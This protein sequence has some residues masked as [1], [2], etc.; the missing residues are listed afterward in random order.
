MGQTATFSVVASGVG[1]SYQWIGPDGR[2]LSDRLGE[3]E[4]SN[5]ATL[6]IRNSGSSNAASYRC[7][8]SNSGG[9]VTSFPALLT[10]GK[11]CRRLF[12]CFKYCVKVWSCLTPSTELQIPAPSMRVTSTTCVLVAPS[13]WEPLVPWSWRE[14]NAALIRRHCRTPCPSDAS[15]ALVRMLIRIN[16]RCVYVRTLW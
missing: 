16:D 3:I 15:T 10:F 13:G 1:L 8:V 6:E 2:P 9:S 4:G 14:G 12:C 11:Q 7:I 5:A